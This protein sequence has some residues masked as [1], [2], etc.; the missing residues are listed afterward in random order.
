MMLPTTHEGYQLFHSGQI[1]LAAVEAAGMKIDVAYLDK[2]I[3]ETD[4]RIKDL[5]SRLRTDKDCQ[6]VVKAWRK[7][8]GEKTNFGS[9]EQLGTVLFE[10]LKVA[11]GELTETVKRQKEA[12]K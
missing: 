12:G 2:K 6:K 1:A 5:A 8:Y 4:K 9:R 7:R 3:A 11:G 10:V